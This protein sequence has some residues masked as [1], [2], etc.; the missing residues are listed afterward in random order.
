MKNPWDTID[1]SDDSYI[2]FAD[3]AKER[4]EQLITLKAWLVIEI[5]LLMN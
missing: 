2:G 4:Q 3:R 5:K 1:F